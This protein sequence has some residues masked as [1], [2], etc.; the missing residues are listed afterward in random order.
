MPAQV[1]TIA[2]GLAPTL[3]IA[4]TLLVARFSIASMDTSVRSAFLA[5][6]VP[7]L[8]RTRFLGIINVCKTLSNS[9]GYSLAGQLA[10]MRLMNYGFVICGMMKLC[11]DLGLLIGFK[12]VRLEHWR[13]SLLDPS[14][15]ESDRWLR[16]TAIGFSGGCCS[17][18]WWAMM[19]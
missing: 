15:W 9:L 14:F 13:S 19:W 6:I 17:Q 10:E 2:F 4:L 1:L 18:G 7:E 3:P 12:T 11:Y 5:A 16:M 8:H